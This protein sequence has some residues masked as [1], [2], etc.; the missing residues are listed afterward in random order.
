[1]KEFTLAGALL[2]ASLSAF[3]APEQYQMT[4]PVLAVDDTKITIEKEGVSREFARDASTKVTGDLKVGGKATVYYKLVAVSA[5]AKP[6]GSAD[7][8]DKSPDAGKKK[9]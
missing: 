1:M 8:P 3:A 9:K 5:E 2:L 7:A 4:G 6:A